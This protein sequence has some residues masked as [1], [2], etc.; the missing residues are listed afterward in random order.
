VETLET[1]DAPLGIEERSGSGHLGRAAA[2][3]MGAYVLSR[4]LGLVR[5]MVISQQFGTSRALDAYRAAF[6]IPDLLFALIAGGALGSAFIPTFTTYL[7]HGRQKESWRLAS[8]VFNLAL[9]CLTASAVV[10]GVLAPQLVILI[11]PGFR[12]DPASLGLTADL[13]RIML[14]SPILAGLSGIVMGVLNSHNRFLLPAL[15]PVVYNLGIIGGAIF[16]APTMGVRGL[17]A[18]VAVGAGL[19]LLIQIPGLLKLRPVYSLHLGL[20]DPGVREVGRLMLPRV[21]G[22][23]A[24]QLNYVVNTILASTLLPGS[25][26]A[27][28]FAWQL[29]TLPWGIFAMAISTVSF[30]TLA[31]A[32]AR[33]EMAALKSTLSTA[34]RTILYLT[35]PA[36]VGLFVLRE[37]LVALLF[38]RGQFDAASTRSVAWALAFYAPGLFALAVTEIVTRAFYALHDTRTPVTI[39]V[40]T[41]GANIILSLILIGPLAHGGLALAATLANTGET[42]VLLAVLRRR[43]AGLDGGRLIGSTARSVAAAL[44]MGAVLA[45]AWPI[46]SALGVVVGTCVDVGLGGAVYVGITWVLGSE[47]LAWLRRRARPVSAAAIPVAMPDAQPDAT[48]RTR[49]FLHRRIGRR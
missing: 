41:F 36:G 22:L 9:I 45:L 5:E 20:R 25:L 42:L 21:L 16:L 47:E 39:A 4:A 37:P 49:P 48:V 12:D 11:V 34:L 28:T 33:D 23:A 29:T 32:A 13:V 17:A 14:F 24:M 18:G 2:L 26:A 38:Q 35:I 10:V 1:D 30:P 7:T 40:V 8:A 15:A 44:A 19:H 27:L 31:A 46:T 6:N 43:L 3:V